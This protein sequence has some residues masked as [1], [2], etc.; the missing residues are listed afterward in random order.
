[1]CGGDLYE[2]G[3][4]RGVTKVLRKRWAYLRGEAI[5]GGTYR[6]RNTVSCSL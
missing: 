5:R 3:L 6:R 4:I 1:M 2:G